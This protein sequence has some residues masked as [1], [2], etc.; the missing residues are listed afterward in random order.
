MVNKYD[1]PMFIRFDW[2][3]V[4]KDKNRIVGAIV[5]YLT[6]N[7]EI[8]VSDW[9]VDKAYQHEDIGLHL[10]KKLIQAVKSRNIITLIDSKNEPSLL[11]HKEMGFKIVRSIKN[12]YGLVGGLESG[13]RILVRLKKI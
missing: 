8:F 9:V 3:F 6:R 7:N 12:A 5:A 1:E 13:N 11:A 10:Y 4:A 2:C